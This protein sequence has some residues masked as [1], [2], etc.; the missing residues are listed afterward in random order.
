VAVVCEQTD[1]G[2][3][4]KEASCSCGYLH[5]KGYPC[6]HVLRVALHL[7]VTLLAEDL[8]VARWH[9]QDTQATGRAAAGGATIIRPTAA[10][11]DVDCEGAGADD[12]MM[13]EGVDATMRDMVFEVTAMVEEM[14]GGRGMLEPRALAAVQH[15]QK[16]LQVIVRTKGEVLSVLSSYAERL[17]VCHASER[18][19][20]MHG[21]GGSLGS[22]AVEGPETLP[23]TEEGGGGGR[24]RQSIVSGR[25][26]RQQKP[27]KR[28]HVGGEALDVAGGAGGDV[29]SSVGGGS[30]SLL[31]PPKRARPDLSEGTAHP[32]V[33]SAKLAPAVEEEGIGGGGDGGPGAAESERPSTVFRLRITRPGV[34]PVAIAQPS[35]AAA[36]SGKEN[37]GTR[38]GESG[39]GKEGPPSA[40]IPRLRIACEPGQPMPH[41]PLKLRL[42]VPTLGES[43][44]S[45]GGLTDHHNEER[46]EQH[47]Q[48]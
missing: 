1:K 21:A 19:V 16:L 10:R 24:S 26:A 7:D 40:G 44:A 13:L 27:K 47:G 14:G 8:V 17:D 31:P 39:D 12:A 11:P 4:M 42:L 3:L 2:V 34:A 23:P 20:G 43:Q 28:K 22:A 15:F 46:Q 37:G 18:A 32:P 30:S 41:R 36:P 29:P 35:M 9:V 38:D 33:S 48:Q 25:K 45:T 5:T 6:R